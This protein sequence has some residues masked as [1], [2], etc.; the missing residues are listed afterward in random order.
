[1]DTGAEEEAGNHCYRKHWIKPKES[2][3]GPSQTSS[4]LFISSFLQPYPSVHGLWPNHH[5]AE[6]EQP[7][8]VPRT[9]SRPY[10]SWTTPPPRLRRLARHRQLFQEYPS[11][12]GPQ[13]C[14]GA[15][16]LMES[17]LPSVK[18]PAMDDL[19]IVVQNISNP[20]TAAKL[21]NLISSF[22]VS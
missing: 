11:S 7:A 2:R 20:S 10:S 18:Q 19:W 21:G 9:K 16:V 8:L 17:L 13:A 1:M 15:G 3:Q 4:L 12:S 6:F 14:P 5:F 22:L